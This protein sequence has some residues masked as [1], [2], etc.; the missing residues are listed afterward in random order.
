MENT[1]QAGA[2]H[3]YLRVR[4]SIQMFLQFATWG[5]WLPVLGN[6]M[7][8]M[9]A[10]GDQIG[11]VYF[12][13]PLALMIAPL[14][15]GQIA[16]RFFAT[17][18]YLSFSYLGT[19][20]CLYGISQS[21]DYNTVWWLA[22][23]G[24]IFFG[25]TLGLAN[26][27]SFSHMKDGSRDFP[28]VRMFG[29]I[30]WIAAGWVLGYAMTLTGKSYVVAFQIGALF[31]FIN[32]IFVLT[33]PHT[34]PKRDAGESFA[35]G[36]VL[37]M[38]GDPSFIV[39]TFLAFVILIF[40]TFYYNFGGLFM[41][42]GMAVQKENVSRVMSIGQIMEI[43]TMLVLG[44]ALARFGF[45]TVIAIGIVAW[46]ARFGIFALGTPKELVIAA[47]GLHGVCFAFSLAAAMIYVDKISPPDI[48][49]SMQSFLSFVTYGLGMAVGS[50][51]AGKVLGHYTVNDVT[52]WHGLWMIPTLGCAV[53][54]VLFLAIF[55]SR[56]PREVATPTPNEGTQPVAA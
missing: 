29:T 20:A 8:E 25:P 31:S 44:P 36:K 49:G 14:L 22:L 13:G 39:F 48:K 9:K 6:H 45:K 33:L 4:L 5:A 24:M 53:V 7:A 26:S 23:A 47:Q 27:L 43:L 3:S 2:P 21:Q 18:Y 19:A 15:A 51:V 28:I 32:A 16:D 41:E 40:A 54:L 17:Q 52:N 42:K 38:L 12:T 34:P 30:G 50:V 55:R 35:A 1:L 11:Y 37:K 46:G 10:T 56:V